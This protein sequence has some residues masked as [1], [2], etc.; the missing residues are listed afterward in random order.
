MRVLLVEDDALIGRSL[1]RALQD[2]GA[3]VDWA[4]T[5]SDALLAL[6]GGRYSAVLLDLGL[7]G[8]SGLDV[9]KEMRHRCDTTPVLIVT[10]RDDV[11][12]RVAGLDGGADDFI[13]K[14][15]DFDELAARLRAVVRRHA[16]HATS[17]V[18]SAEIVLD[19]ASHEAS[20]RGKTEVLPQREFALMHALMERPG[21]ILSRSQLEE[22]IYG[23]G[24]E[25]ES[26][27]IDVLI[28][29]LRRRFDKEVIR[30]V[31]GSGWMVPK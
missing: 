5:G 14:P 31:R 22:A 20:Y 25:I 6:R 13:I 30:N 21:A 27:A 19:L 8:R 11:E 29:Y 28:H 10:A 18:R 1:V 4:H 24:E 23:W 17:Q 15:F 12:T 2:T 3:A 9:L 16:G 26:N 7:P